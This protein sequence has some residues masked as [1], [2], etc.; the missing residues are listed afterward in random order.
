MSRQTALK[1]S[2]VE[3]SPSLS[4]HF[5]LTL[6]IDRRLAGSPIVPVAGDTLSI[7]GRKMRAL[8]TLVLDDRESSGQNGALG[9]VISLCADEVA[10][11]NF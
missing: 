6:A 7:G 4:G 9:R 10:R 5:C 11:A 8:A 1:S 3:K 2:F